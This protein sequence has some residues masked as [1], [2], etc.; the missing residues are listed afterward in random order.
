MP[1]IRM[2][3][4][5]TLSMHVIHCPKCVSQQAEIDDVSA[6]V[7]KS[8]TPE[9]AGEACKEALSTLRRQD[10]LKCNNT[11]L[12]ICA[13]W[14]S[15][16]RIK[17]D[18]P[19]HFG[20]TAQKFE[21]RGIARFVSAV[22]TKIELKIPEWW[23]DLLKDVNSDSRPEGETWVTIPQSIETMND[24]QLA[25]QYKE[26][27]IEVPITVLSWVS[28][29]DE[30]SGDFT[31]QA[32][33]SV[34]V[35]DDFCFVISKPELWGSSRI[36]E[37]DRAN[38]TERWRNA[39]WGEGQHFTIST[40]PAVVTNVAQSFVIGTEVVTVFGA[41][42][43][44]VGTYEPGASVFGTEGKV[45]PGQHIDAVFFIE[46]FDRNDGSAR[47]RFASNLWHNYDNVWDRI[48][49]PKSNRE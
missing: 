9:E 36:M 17:R 15:H 44:G 46:Q 49:S 35:E 23:I 16:C 37:L 41:V 42:S 18:S 6:A 43:R 2:L 29:G 21:A 12:A 1:S 47:F 8:T 3:C 19:P 10:L 33:L 40:G 20:F 31:R 5:A 48:R 11:T 13:A 28:S 4:L 26:G 14:Q 34:L 38:R 25:L 27:T 22:E 30:Q 45:K 39:T 24:C 7:S 32:A